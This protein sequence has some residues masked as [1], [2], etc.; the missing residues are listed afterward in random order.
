MVDP[1]LERLSA[2]HPKAIDL[3]LDRIERLL[4]AL[5]NPQAALPPVVH[6]AGTNGKGSV[7]AFLRAIFE[8]AG[9]RV[10]AYISPHLVRFNERIRLSGRLI[11]E[12]AL[13]RLLARCEAANE[14]KAITFFEITTAAAFLAFA[15]AR[16]AGDVLLLET[17]LG[18]RLDA[19]NLVARPLLSVLT[20]IAMDHT[21]FLGPSLEGIAAEKAAILKPGVPAII[22]PQ[23]RAAAAVIKARAQAIH[24]PLF[25]A[26]QE[27]SIA[28]TGEGMEYRDGMGAIPLPLPALAGDHQIE[29]AG[30]A[31]AAARA[32]VARECVARSCMV[33]GD[34]GGSAVHDGA[35]RVGADFS[36]SNAALAEGLQKVRW[37]A[38]LQRLLRGPLLALLPPGAELWIDGGHNA[39]AGAALGR[40]AGA[41]PYPLSLV[42]GMMATKDPEAFLKPLAP[43]VDVFCAVPIAGSSAAA[44]SP[45]ALVA[46]AR[47]VGIEKAFA[48]DDPGSAIRRVVAA[49][50]PPAPRVL[51][52]GSLYL[53]G[54]VLGPEFPPDPLS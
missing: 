54:E 45:A 28:V 21:Q 14:K 37:P 29:N 44:L 5:G 2:L 24:A 7:I 8:A 20:P 25:R 43:Y 39:H 19:T 22:G 36:I 47:R 6:V 16:A 27:W 34:T 53:A 32:C 13:A 30:I 1:I 35:V 33:H 50:S 46:A 49:G 18:G 51:M 31:V 3:S 17:G 41:Q 42:V 40:W 4:A 12:A 23:R 11:D 10:H 38:R 48:A 26:G 52:A 9:Y 15:E